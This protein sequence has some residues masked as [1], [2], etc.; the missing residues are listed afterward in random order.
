MQKQVSVLKTRRSEG[1]VR[2]GGRER[3]RGNLEVQKRIGV[4]VAEVNDAVAEVEF[5]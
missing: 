5:A 3:E 1:D 2:E 4:L